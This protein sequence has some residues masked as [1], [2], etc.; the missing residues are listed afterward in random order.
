M[1][2]ARTGFWEMAAIVG[3]VM[4][5]V[6]VMA[7]CTL[8]YAAAEQAKVEHTSSTKK[9]EQFIEEQRERSQIP[10]MSVVIVEKGKTMFEKGFGY[11]DLDSKKPVTE[12]TLFELGSTTKAFTGLAIL[13]LEKAGLINR[14]DDVR[15]YLPWFT[16][17]N[18]GKSAAITIGQLL[19]HTSGISARTIA[20]IP[21]DD[22]DRALEK[23]VRMLLGQ[24][25]DRKPGSSHEYATIN[26]DVLGLV[27]E[28][29][30][31]QSYEAY[32]KQHV[33]EPLGMTDSFV[34][35]QSVLPSEMATGYR[36]GF[37]KPREY[38]PPIYR[39][40][41]PAGY[42]VSNSIDI[43]KWMN[44]QLGYGLNEQVS[45]A[46]VQESHMPDKSVAPIDDTYYASGWSIGEDQNL[47]MHAGANPS[48][49]SYIILQQ[50]RQLGVAVIANVMSDAT[51]AIGQSVLTLWKGDNLSNPV[52][53]DRMQALDQAATIAAGITGG[54]ALLGWLAGGRLVWSIARRKRVLVSLGVMRVIGFVALLLVCAGGICLVLALPKLFL[55]G[56]PWSFI[57]VWS[58]PTIVFVACCLA[59]MFA[60]W[61]IYGAL[62]IVT[63]KTG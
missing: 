7:T 13:Q 3:C 11:A 39:G 14:T 34:G 12:H 1:N 57:A 28:Q 31:K 25:L 45:K 38:H 35:I 51:A 17:N 56:M 30:T 53:N 55:E 44:A 40:N 48:F 59:A 23:T 9:I 36:V 16:M 8:P 15:K 10:G 33:L 6:L 24:Q 42:L 4:L 43:A 21:E 27:I 46:L 20:L 50:D 47:I 61:F 29:V 54:L 63:K 49:S 37:L 62:K 18:E 52:P 2:T 5:V 41:N 19:Y 26:Y 22:T 60:G 32:I 58:P